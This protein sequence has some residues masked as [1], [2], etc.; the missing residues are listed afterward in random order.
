MQVDTGT[1]K[2]RKPLV[3]ME[4]N[5][6]YM[7]TLCKDKSALQKLAVATQHRKRLSI[8]TYMINKKGLQQ[9]TATP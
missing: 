4:V 2:F 5:I 9:L 7:Y 6:V 1:Q 3:F 8:G